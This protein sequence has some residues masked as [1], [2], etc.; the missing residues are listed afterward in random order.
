MAKTNKQCFYDS[1]SQL[2]SCSTCKKILPVASFSKSTAIS[3][4]YK[5]QCRECSAIRFQAWKGKQ[6][7]E[8]LRIRDRKSQYRSNYG[9]D[10]ETINKLIE[11]R[12][13]I[14]SI[15]GEVH[16]LVVDHCHTTGKVRGFICS[17]CNSMLGYSKDNKKTLKNA[18]KYLED[19]YVS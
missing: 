12:T 7:I 16:P 15:C 9:L 1:E 10:E 11:D 19:F 2:K 14:C 17:A 6:D 13:G 3:H 5:S 4:G 18:I 8:E